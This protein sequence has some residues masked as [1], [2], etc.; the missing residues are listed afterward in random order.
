MKLRIARPTEDASLMLAA[1][2]LY[3][4]ANYRA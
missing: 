3:E 1:A 2:L 4:R